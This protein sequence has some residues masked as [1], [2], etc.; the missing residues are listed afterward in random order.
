MLSSVN[1]S[2]G[3]LLANLQIYMHHQPR[4][5]FQLKNNNCFLSKVNLSPWTL[6]PIPSGFFED[7]TLPRVLCY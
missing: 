3:F 4:S 5:G 7:N 2:R 6:N 1:K